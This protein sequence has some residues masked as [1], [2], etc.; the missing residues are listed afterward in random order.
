[1]ADRGRSVR[2]FQESRQ[3]IIERYRAIDSSNIGFLRARLQE[4]CLHRVHSDIWSQFLGL[5][6]IVSNVDTVIQATLGA[7]K[8][9]TQH[10]LQNTI[11]K[12]QEFEH[13]ND[14][15]E[16]G[17]G[18]LQY[19]HIV[20][21]EFFLRNDGDHDTEHV[22]LDPEFVKI[23]SLQVAEHIS[24]FLAN[25]WREN[26]GRGKARRPLSDDRGISISTMLQS[27]YPGADPRHYVRIKAESFFQHLLRSAQYEDRGIDRKFRVALQRDLEQLKM[28]RT[29][30]QLTSKRSLLLA[31]VPSVLKLL[32]EHKFVKAVEL[33]R[34]FL[35]Q[36]LSGVELMQESHQ[37]TLAVF[38]YCCLTCDDAPRVDYDPDLLV[39]LVKHAR[40]A[41]LSVL[42]QLNTPEKP[43][44]ERLLQAETTFLH[45]F[46]LKNNRLPFSFLQ[47][48]AD[49][50][51]LATK[52]NSMGGS[53]DDEALREPSLVLRYTKEEI[54][55]LV[56]DLLNEV[57]SQSNHR[58]PCWSVLL[59]VETCARRQANVVA[60]EKLGLGSFLQFLNESAR[61]SSTLS[62]LMQCTNETPKQAQSFST[63][64]V[65]LDEMQGFVDFLIK[66]WLTGATTSKIHDTAFEESILNVV[67]RF[68]DLPSSQIRNDVSSLLRQHSGASSIQEHVAVANVTNIHISNY[69]L[70]PSLS[71]QQH[72][73][74][75]LMKQCPY[76]VD[77]AEWLDWQNLFADHNGRFNTFLNELPPNILCDSGIRLLQISHRSF[78]RILESTASR[79]IQNYLDVLNPARLALYVASIA[80]DRLESVECGETHLYQQAIGRFLES[81][82]PLQAGMYIHSCL[83]LLPN[84]YRISLGYSLL[85]QEYIKTHQR[86]FDLASLSSSPMH[87]AYYQRIG[88]LYGVDLWDSMDCS[89][90]GYSNHSIKVSPLSKTTSESLSRTISVV[91]ADSS[92][93]GETNV[94]TETNICPQVEDV[95]MSPGEVCGLFQSIQAKYGV[96]LD[97]DGF[98]K[99]KSLSA[100]ESNLTSALSESLKKLGDELY[101]DEV[102]YLLELVQNC[103]DNSYADNVTPTLRIKVNKDRLEL[104]NNEIGF[105]QAN[106]EA[107]CAIAKSTKA[108]VRGYIGHKGIGFKS[109]FKVTKTPFIHS[110]SFHFSFDSDQLLG[111]IV[112]REEPAPQHWQAHQGTRLILPFNKPDETVSQS[113]MI[114]SHLLMFLHR[115][116]VIDIE[117]EWPQY[118]RVVYKKIET[119]DGLLLINESRYSSPQ[120]SDK[121]EQR[122]LWLIVSTTFEASCSRNRGDARDT[123]TESKVSLAFPVDLD[124]DHPITLKPQP[125]FAFL[126]LRSFGFNFVIQADFNTTSSRESID[127]SSAWNASIRAR[128]APLFRDAVQQFVLRSK[129]A[130]SR[131]NQYEAPVDNLE[132]EFQLDDQSENDIGDSSSVDK[133]IKSTSIEQLEAI[134]WMNLIY[135][136]IPTDDKLEFF[137]SVPREIVQHLKKIPFILTSKFDFV[138]PSQAVL[139]PNTEDSVF[140]LEKSLNECGYYFMH[141]SC[142]ISH[143]VAISLGIRELTGEL[144]CDALEQL[145]K[146]WK[147]ADDVEIEFVVWAL[148]HLV[149]H[150][151]VVR[152]RFS[153]LDLLPCLDG[154]IASI[155]SHIFYARTP[156]SIGFS[157]SK[158]RGALLHPKMTVFILRQD[159]GEFILKRWGLRD[160]NSHEFLISVV[161]PALESIETLNDQLVAMLSF[162]IQHLSQS[163]ECTR[164]Q[165]NKGDALFSDIQDRNIRIVTESGQAV[166]CRR[167]PVFMPLRTFG[168]KARSFLTKTGWNFVNSM[169]LHFHTSKKPMDDVIWRGVLAAAGVFPS[170]SFHKI[171]RTMGIKE[172]FKKYEALR[173]QNLEELDAETQ[174]VVV[175][176]VSSELSEILDQIKVDKV[177][178]LALS[179]GLAEFLSHCLKIKPLPSATA[180]VGS[181]PRTFQVPS[182][183]TLELRSRAWVSVDGEL[184]Q[185]AELF[186]LNEATKP[187]VK[188]HQT[189][190]ASV[191]PLSLEQLMAELGAR[192]RIL[193]NDA[194]KLLRSWSKRM[195]SNLSISHLA[196]VYAII[197]DAALANE[198]IATIM[199]TEPLFFIP[200]YRQAAYQSRDKLLVDPDK[201]CS[202]S[203][204][205]WAACAIEDKSHTIDSYKE[206]MSET[207]AGIVSDAIG[208]MRILGSFYPR[209]FIVHFRNLGVK[210]TPTVEQYVQILEGASRY[211][212]LNHPDVLSLTVRLLGSFSYA[213]MEGIQLPA[214]DRAGQLDDIDESADRSAYVLRQQL[215]HLFSQHK[216]IPTCSLHWTALADAVIDDSSNQ[217][218]RILAKLG[219]NAVLLDPG[220]AIFKAK[221]NLERFYTL[222][223]IPKLA[224]ILRANAAFDLCDDALP[225]PVRS[226][227]HVIAALVYIQRASLH[228]PSRQ[229]VSDKMHTIEINVVSNLRKRIYTSMN[230]AEYFEPTVCIAHDSKLHI[231]QLADQ[232]LQLLLDTLLDEL[233]GYG[234]LDQESQ[235]GLRKLFGQ[236]TIELHSSMPVMS[237]TM[238]ISLVDRILRE[239]Q[240]LPFEPDFDEAVWCKFED[241]LDSSVKSQENIHDQV[242]V[243]ESI[244]RNDF[245]ENDKAA[246]YFGRVGEELLRNRL[247]QPQPQRHTHIVRPYDQ[248]NYGR[249]VSGPASAGSS[250]AVDINPRVMTSATF[251]PPSVIVTRQYDDYLELPA[252]S[253]EAVLE[254]HSFNLIDRNISQ[255]A[256]GF[257]FKI[258]SGE[259]EFKN[260]VWANI[261]GE[262]GLPYDISATI[263]DRDVFVEVKSCRTFGKQSFDISL[264]ELAFAQLRGKSYFIYWVYCPSREQLSVVRFQDPVAGISAEG[265]LGLQVLM[266]RRVLVTDL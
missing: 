107:I 123:T 71:L 61:C 103:D 87:V 77:M 44:S 121:I 64:S 110:Q 52:L 89:F 241:A 113:R 80:I 226:S 194:I 106:V 181:I 9:I 1:M 163:A 206:D 125:V 101:G 265:G 207:V 157:F 34:L 170:I 68:F 57:L 15:P 20:Q 36:N 43:L 173:G 262:S 184:E 24:L 213:D 250:V 228:H 38:I 248:T 156:N 42:D 90:F 37:K 6:R 50:E 158:K 109:V 247:N 260:V 82:E 182:Q 19:N 13:F 51:H 119:D 188:P 131:C 132:D 30:L 227:R 233:C 75:S 204:Y 179:T 46:N 154:S 186:I 22:Q 195:A 59:E 159:K 210:R 167:D 196:R 98:R 48:V 60:F 162:Y 67:S 94:A 249:G 141:P 177:H 105:S 108:F 127:M 7:S 143:E 216:I 212:L 118:E 11:M 171:E 224:D 86:V 55:E 147:S 221:E 27:L 88:H 164:C 237:S 62:A 47:F 2:A 222:M 203:F 58:S 41:V 129:L 209:N 225:Y 122:N 208:E 65:S 191:A 104:S 97:Q 201:E 145:A 219:L 111:Y 258:L 31:N 183:I 53:S 243:D 149:S 130:L 117:T 70:V 21:Q 137:R 84:S 254:V 54:S 96:E 151:L 238:I 169:Y 124:P 23:S 236:L 79:R 16:A 168:D 239:V 114:K 14:F 72:K 178:Q 160:V 99:H 144:L 138:M 200:R 4:R 214:G 49:N 115:L 25:E 220:T 148:M 32:R 223:Q 244:C 174:V 40:T 93:Q 190:L 91:S 230:T 74:V 45:Q 134:R 202:G 66:N 139:I 73:I 29:D 83:F 155:D 128:I 197:A 218:R 199:K 10:D 69:E 256:E 175:D 39:D 76:M 240:I 142:R 263:D 189:A 211:P 153:A 63:C 193:P 232:N 217:G 198:K 85:V 266:K 180:Q 81:L 259:A 229:S 146:S 136:S 17:I 242:T 140:L 235:R 257:V 215:V 126:P 102:H 26:N 252:A 246:A 187:I 152:K 3:W 116:R 92:V 112:P 205:S 12:L 150:D 255:W 185:P 234:L 245:D 28:E 18:Q 172:A 176:Y 166:M 35:S 264:N 192:T 135:Q 78:I 165:G 133:V 33:L 8:L 253:V 120:S 5:Q 95:K 56:I 161:I 231:S 100:V 261:N 251:G